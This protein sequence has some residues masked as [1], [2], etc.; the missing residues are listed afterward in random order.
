MQLGGGLYASVSL[1]E[2][3]GLLRKGVALRRDR[4]RI[5]GDWGMLCLTDR[6]LVWL[7]MKRFVHL[8]SLWFLKRRDLM[9]LPLAAIGTVD[10]WGAALVIEMEPERYE[11]S[12]P[13]AYPLM[14]SKASEWKQSVEEARSES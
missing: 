13:R 6:R 4:G 1:E 14:G 12:V 5:A 8:V 2:G 10:T 3:E 7:P 9:I 11:F